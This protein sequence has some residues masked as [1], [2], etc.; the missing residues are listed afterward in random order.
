VYENSGLPPCR[1]KEAA[2]GLIDGIQAVTDIQSITAEIRGLAAAGD[3]VFSER[4]DHHFDSKGVE[5]LT[6]QICGVM[7]VR[8]GKIVAWRDYFDP[9]PLLAGMADHQ[10]G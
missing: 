10:A 8:G 2:L 3:L 7:E 5:N 6:P 1:G 9:A 4:I